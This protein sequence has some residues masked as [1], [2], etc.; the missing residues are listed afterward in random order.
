MTTA[1]GDTNFVR[2]DSNTRKAYYAPSSNDRPQN[3]VLNYVYE[4]PGKGTNLLTKALLNGWQISGLTL[5]Q[6]G[7]PF[8]PGFAI[9]GVSNQNITGSTTEG[10][11]I[12]VVPAVNP[13][14][15]SDDP[16]NRINAAAFTTPR[17]PICP[18]PTTCQASI[19]LESGVNYLYGPGLANYDLSVQKTF[20]LRERMSI[21]LRADAFNVFNHTQ[22]SGINSTLNFAVLNPTTNQYVNATTSQNGVF[23]SVINGNFIPVTPNNLTVN[24]NGSTNINGFGTINGTRSAGAGGSPRFL[25]LV[26]RFRF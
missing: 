16:Y 19:G 5:F 12:G 7:A 14:T 10:A 6:S 17:A 22:F 2:V 23:G 8:T 9:N 25:Q 1:P 15:G 18:T 3:F 4:V 13:N 20:R 11:R 21:E 26:A 24:A